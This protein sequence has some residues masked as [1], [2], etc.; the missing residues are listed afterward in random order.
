M[1]LALLLL[2]IGG[3]SSCE[4]AAETAACYDRCRAL[5]R[6]CTYERIGFSSFA[7]PFTATDCVCTCD[8]PMPLD[9][10]R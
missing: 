1:K 2:L 8:F 10:G 6:P 5:P 4:S 3:L 7:H 9:G